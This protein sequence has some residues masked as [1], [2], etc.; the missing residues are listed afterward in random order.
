MYRYVCREITTDCQL[1]TRAKK[2]R[3]A[4][5]NIKTEI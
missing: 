2:E 5:V 4:G 1:G 3:A